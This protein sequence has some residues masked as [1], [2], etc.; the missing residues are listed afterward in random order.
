MGDSRAK[1]WADTLQGVREEGTGRPK[2]EGKEGFAALGV[3]AR[4]SASHRRSRLVRAWLQ[5]AVRADVDSWQKKKWALHGLR[6]E[7]VNR[8]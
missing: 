5:R 4:R 6:I 8:E 7:S 3:L 1:H 2:L